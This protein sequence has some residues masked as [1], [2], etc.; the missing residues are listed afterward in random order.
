M[1]K[2]DRDFKYLLYLWVWFQS[3]MII[4]KWLNVIPV[5][6]WIIALPTWFPVFCA[7][8]LASGSF[9]YVFFS[10]RGKG[11]FS[12]LKNRKLEEY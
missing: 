7:I 8:M 1:N 11:M 6:W 4:L 3:T 9:L 2:I 12:N 10:H 5:S